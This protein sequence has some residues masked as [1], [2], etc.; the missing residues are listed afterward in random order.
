MTSYLAICM[1]KRSLAKSSLCFD[2]SVALVRR[3]ARERF[4]ERATPRCDWSGWSIELP[5]HRL[6]S[7]AGE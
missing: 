6:A 7:G 3:P 5:A 1:P 4:A 2:A